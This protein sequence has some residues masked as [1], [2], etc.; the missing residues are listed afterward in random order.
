MKFGG[1]VASRHYTPWEREETVSIWYSLGQAV[2]L[3]YVQSEASWHELSPA[4]EKLNPDKSCQPW[5]WRTEGTE[6]ALTR[7]VQPLSLY[8]SCQETCI[9]T[10]QTR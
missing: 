5:S 4:L 3:W 9:P 2:S 8:V 1:A 10:E 6:E 7:D